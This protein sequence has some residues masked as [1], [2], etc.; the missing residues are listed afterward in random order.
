MNNRGAVSIEAAIAY[1]IFLFT[2]LA[3]IYMGE[4]YTVR[5]VVYEGAVETAEYMAEYAYLTDCFEDA[6]VMNL[7]MALLRFREYV[8]DETL[9]DRFVVGGCNGVSFLGSSFP[10][11]DGYIDMH[12]TYYVRINAPIVGAYKHKITEHI[13]QK[14]YLGDGSRESSDGEESEDEYVYVA[15]NGVVYHRTRSCTYLLP[16]VK[17]SS[18][19]SAKNNGY[20]ACKYC[21]GGDGVVYITTDGECY[22]SSTACSR[23]RRT[24]SRQKLSEVSLP[25]CSKCAD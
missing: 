25:P 11:D 18:I 19:E 3:M 17:T 20:K 24:V 5:G 1:P 13:K 8:D 22:H 10:D 7:P 23:L 9:L 2:M 14:A 6:Q 4:I 15:E 12:I 16:D 21:G